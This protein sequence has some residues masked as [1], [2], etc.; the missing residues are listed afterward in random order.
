[1]TTITRQK[2]GRKKL[3]KINALKQKLN[4]TDEEWE[5]LKG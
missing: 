3:E 2:L 4:L 1:M 5:L